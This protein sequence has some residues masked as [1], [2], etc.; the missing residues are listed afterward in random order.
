MYGL[1]FN[2]DPRLEQFW[3]KHISFFGIENA[4]VRNRPREVK[5]RYEAIDIE[6]Y[7]EL[8]KNRPLILLQH[9]NAPHI[10]PEKELHE[11]KPDT[12]NIYV[13]GLDTAD[14]KPE[15]FEDSNYKSCVSVTHSSE[16]NYSFM[17]ASI[18]FYYLQGLS[19]GN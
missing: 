19:N 15:E 5:K 18:V 13:F 11:H 2:Y 12:D 4:W 1:C 14:A 16:D 8:P 3:D 10:K 7:S 17:I 9:V 6:S